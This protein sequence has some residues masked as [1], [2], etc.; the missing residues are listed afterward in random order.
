VASAEQKPHEINA[1]V[2]YMNGAMTVFDF[3]S[4]RLFPNTGH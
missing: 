1:R 4:P 3:L 2:A